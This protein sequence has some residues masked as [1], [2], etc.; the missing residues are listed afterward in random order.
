VQSLQVVRTRL[1]DTAHLSEPAQQAI[2]ELMLAL[3]AGSEK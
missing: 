3:V 2:N 1:V